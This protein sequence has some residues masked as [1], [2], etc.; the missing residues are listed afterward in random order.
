MQ[1]GTERIAYQRPPEPKGKLIVI[2]GT[3]ASGKSALGV[4][5][6]KRFDGEIVSDSGAEEAPVPSR[7]RSLGGSHRPRHVSRRK[8]GEVR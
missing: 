2:A 1:D 8:G 6:A 7:P 3:N 5:V 4:E